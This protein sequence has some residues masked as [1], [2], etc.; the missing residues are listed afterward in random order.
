MKLAEAVLKLYN[1]REQRSLPQA[2]VSNKEAMDMIHA[3]IDNMVY[4]IRQS[5]KG[6]RS[7]HKDWSK[8]A[9]EDE[10]NTSSKS[11]F[12]SYL[13][14]IFNGSGTVQKFLSAAKM[15][16]GVVWNR[17][18]LAAIDRLENGYEN[19]HGYDRPSKE[20]LDLIKNI[21]VA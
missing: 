9:G 18:A 4:E 6:Q 3:E 1:E 17:V 16:K 8:M 7:G 2:Y 20:F 21:Q 5:E 15:G 10:V 11:T 12:P 13:Q 19:K 14:D